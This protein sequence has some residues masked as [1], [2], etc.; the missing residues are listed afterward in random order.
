MERENEPFQETCDKKDTCIVVQE[1][2]KEIEHLEVENENLR[3]VFEIA[4]VEFAKKNHRIKKFETELVRLWDIIGSR[5]KRIEELEKKLEEKEARNNL[6]EKIAFGRKSEKKESEEIFMSLT[7]F[8]E[9][10]P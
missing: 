8:F 1:L 5:D 2:L 10:L 3:R 9:K 4:T 6:L 7:S